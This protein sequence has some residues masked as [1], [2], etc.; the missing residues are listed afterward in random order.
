MAFYGCFFNFDGIP[1]FEYGLMVYDIGGENEDGTFS[2]TVQLLEDR[3]TRRY[4]PLHYGATNNEPLTFSFTFGADMSAIDKG[5]YLDRWD[6]D[7]I[8]NWLTGHDQ[9][10]YLEITQPDMESVRY[11]CIISELEYTTYGKMP[12]ALTCKVTCDSPYAYAYPETFKF[13]SPST[14]RCAVESRAACKYYYPKI[15]IQISKGSSFGIINHSDNNRMFSFSNLPSSPITLYIDN[16]NEIITNSKDLNI[17]D[18]FNFNFFRFVRGYNDLEFV[19]SADI[20][21]EC[22][23]PINVGG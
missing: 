23:F 16:E 20:S 5:V 12:W 8:A 15:K 2:S 17:Y 21:F 7:A 14:T 1:C 4:S 9:Y 13:H 18:C 3:T 22:E 10:K 6:M 11:K 19:G